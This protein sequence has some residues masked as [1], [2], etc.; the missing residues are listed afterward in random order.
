LR[1]RE[2]LVGGAATFLLA[3]CAA[4]QAMTPAT[5]GTLTAP[6]TTSATASGTAAA[7]PVTIRLESYN[8]GTPG[9]GG[10]ALQ[11]M[12]DEFQ[13]L[14]PSI[15]IEGKNTSPTPDGQ[16]N[17]IVTERAAGDPPDIAQLGLNSV[18][19]AVRELGAQPIDQFA[20]K[21]EYDA[22]MQHILPTAR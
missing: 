5:T 16:M 18:D 6:A 21:D 17:M 9:L 15:T 14:H 12:I 2:L 20:P 7:Q 13:S 8:Y 3:A 1:R 19:Y 11:T 4:P 10:K 22:L